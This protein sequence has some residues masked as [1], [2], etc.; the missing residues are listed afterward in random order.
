MNLRK[1]IIREIDVKHEQ[2]MR[3]FSPDD[4]GKT[5]KILGLACWLQTLKEDIESPGGGFQFQKEKGGD[6]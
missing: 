4:P 1:D 3:Q 6:G 2:L 5:R